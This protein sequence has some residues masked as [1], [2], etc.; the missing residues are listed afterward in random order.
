MKIIRKEI[1]LHWQL[2]PQYV[3]VQSTSDV[4]MTILVEYAAFL[5]MP[6]K[7]DIVLQLFVSL[8]LIIC[9]FQYQQINRVCS[10][11]HLSIIP[12]RI[13]MFFGRRVIYR[14]NIIS[15]QAKIKH[16]YIYRYLN[17]DC[18]SLNSQ[19]MQYFNQ[20]GPVIL[21]QK[22]RYMYSLL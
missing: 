7:K 21:Y 14:G 9:L 3:Q 19:Q 22:K 18:F 12:S 15:C 13:S 2:F 20:D 1:Q 10:I 8:H 11:Y 4:V 5:V 16:N 17:I 6:T